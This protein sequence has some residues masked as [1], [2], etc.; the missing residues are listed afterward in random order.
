MGLGPGFSG[1]KAHE[2][3]PM[4]GCSAVPSVRSIAK[5]RVAL[6][7]PCALRRFWSNGNGVE[8]ITFQGRPAG[9]PEPISRLWLA[10][11][12]VAIQVPSESLDYSKDFTEMLNSHQINTLQCIS[13]QRLAFK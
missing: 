1:V 5:D 7:Q 3:P 4:T 10:S 9:S 6:I 2:T 13:R 8:F 12:K 11:R